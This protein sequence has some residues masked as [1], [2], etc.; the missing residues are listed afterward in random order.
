MEKEKEKEKEAEKEAEKT[1]SKKARKRWAKKL[2]REK[3]KKR[4]KRTLHRD[5]LITTTKKE[6]QL[7][8]IKE[9]EYV[10]KNGLR[11]V[12]PYAYTFRVFTKQ[13]WLGKTLMQLFTDEFASQPVEFYRRG[14]QL[15]MIQVN[16]EKKDRRIY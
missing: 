13:R 8:Y 5:R 9:T 6:L 1:M 2:E 12:T 7:A 3:N 4:P 11:F 16:G 10:L 14:I 15:G